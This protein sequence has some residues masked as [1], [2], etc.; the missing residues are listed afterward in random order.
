MFLK[1][2]PGSGRR[3]ARPCRPEPFK[4][5]VFNRLHMSIPVER[6][7]IPVERVSIPVNPLAVVSG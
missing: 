7:S 4:I 6:V 2:L 5:F 3:V 1:S